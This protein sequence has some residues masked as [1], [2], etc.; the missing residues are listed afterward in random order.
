VDYEDDATLCHDCDICDQCILN[1]FSRVR[2]SSVLDVSR[3][4]REPELREAIVNFHRNGMQ[5]II[6]PYT[7]LLT[8]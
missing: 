4:L 5:Y 7:L 6:H 3:V 2:L 1:F 8:L